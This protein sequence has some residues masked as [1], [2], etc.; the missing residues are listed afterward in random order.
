LNYVLDATAKSFDAVIVTKDRE[1]QQVEQM[2]HLSVL[3]I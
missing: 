3:W 2:E 1:I